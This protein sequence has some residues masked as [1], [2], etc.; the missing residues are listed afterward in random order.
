MIGLIAQSGLVDYPIQG[1]G[2][3]TVLAIVGL[4]WRIQRRDRRDQESRIKDQ[5]T[6]NAELRKDN[7]RCDYRLNVL[8][9]AMRDAG[10]TVP[11]DV[12][13]PPPWEM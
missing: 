13:A 9:K 7:Q 3:A 5:A 6:I 8:I 10:V 1:V 2:L 12:W 4:L 11:P